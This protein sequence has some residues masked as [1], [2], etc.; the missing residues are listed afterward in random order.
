MRGTSLAQTFVVVRLQQQIQRLFIILDVLDRDNF[1]DTDRFMNYFFTVIRNENTKNSVG[2]FL[3]QNL[4]LLAY[5]IA[6][7]KG[8]TGEKYISSTRKDFWQ[9]FW[10][11]I[12]GGFIISF[13]AISKNLIGKLPLPL[14]WQGAAY[15]A[16]YAA[17]F[18]LMD[19]TNTTLAT[20]QPAY[21]ASA[22]AGSLDTQKNISRPNLSNLAITVGKVAR[23]QIAS[24]AGNLMIVFPLTYALAWLYDFIF[25]VKIASG[26]AALKLLED[27]HPYHSL[28]LLYACFTGFFLFLS[29]LIAGYVENHVIYG[30]ISERLRDHPV[31]THTLSP[32]SLNRVARFIQNSAGGFAGSIMLGLFFGVAGPLGKFLGVH[33]DI[34]H[35]TI[36]A[37]NASIGLYGVGYNNLSGSYLATVIIGVLL[38]GTINFLVSFSLAFFVA[39]KSRGIKLKEYP[40]FLGILFRYMRKHP[41]DFIFPPKRERTVKDIF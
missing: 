37:G 31:F 26:E 4:G 19:S 20:K 22:V 15:G 39:V 38:I 11:A 35:I 9:L 13:I 36:A 32:K 17:G 34:R 18:V 3:S 30:R 14:F 16:N 1:L 41:S 8:R 27:Q 2:E 7:H 23:S 25:G 12:G 21:T 29:G 28:A 10:S 33:F 5:Q 6:E 24:F 40:E